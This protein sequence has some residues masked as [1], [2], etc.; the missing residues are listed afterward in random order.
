VIGWGSCEILIPMSHSLKEKRQVLQ[1]LITLMRK[2]FNIS[3]AETEGQNTWQRSRLEIAL[4]GTSETLVRN[5]FQSIHLFLESN[6][7]ITILNLE[8]QVL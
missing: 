2:Q 8:M 7:E 6:L 4:V 5:A 3:I 1:R